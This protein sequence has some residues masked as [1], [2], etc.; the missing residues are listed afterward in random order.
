MSLPRRRRADGIAALVG[1]RGRMTVR[2]GFASPEGWTTYSPPLE[3][4]QDETLAWRH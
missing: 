3:L 1:R 2:V 4:R